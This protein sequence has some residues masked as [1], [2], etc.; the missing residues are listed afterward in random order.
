MNVQYNKVSATFS[1]NEIMTLTE[2]YNNLILPLI[3]TGVMKG[4]KVTRSSKAAYSETDLDFE[5]QLSTNIA[6]DGKILLQFPNEVFTKNGATALVIKRYSDNK[7]STE[8]KDMS[9][10][11][12]P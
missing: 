12:T 10:S 8:I 1:N 2:N 5:F 4:I 3:K 6:N 11:A 7:Y 9:G